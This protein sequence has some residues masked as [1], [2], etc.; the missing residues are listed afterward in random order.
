MKTIF[1]VDLEDWNH[2]LHIEDKS[3]TSA[4]QAAD[5]LGLLNDNGVKAIYYVLGR[6]KEDWPGHVDYIKS[7]GHIIKSHG[8][9]HYSWEEADRKPYSWLGPTGGFYMR[10]L[11]YWLWKFFVKLYGVAYIHPHDLDEDHPKLSNHIMNWKRH[12]G[13]KTARKK[14]ERLL[15]EVQFENP[16]HLLWKEDKVSVQQV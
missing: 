8:Q 3:H 7:C 14:L 12:V 6:F 13:L 11:P 2:G 10:F 15:K 1:T 5:I 4:Y 16:L 9:N